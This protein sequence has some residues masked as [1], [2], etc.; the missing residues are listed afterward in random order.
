MANDAQKQVYDN[1]LKR[2]VQ[3]QA[4]AIIPLLLGENDCQVLGEENIEV[5]I[6][7]RRSDRIYT[8]AYHDQRVVI[9]IEY[10]SA[11]SNVMD[12]RL[13]IY[14][15][16]LLEK[17]HCPVIS[18]IVYP[19]EVSMA[20]SPLREVLG[21][22]EI[23]S[24]HYR[25]VPLFKL[26]ART[27]VQ[28]GAVQIYGMLPTMEGVSDELLLQALDEMVQFYEKDETLLREELLCFRI[29]LTRAKRLPDAAMLRVERRIRMFDS[30]LENDPW[31]QEKVAEGRVE[32]KL[33]SRR[34]ILVNFIQTRFPALAETAKAKTAQLSQ[35][36]TLNALMTQL[37]LAP[38]EQAARALLETA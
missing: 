14:H 9:D 2:L 29:L 20:T 36:E 8:L 16:V 22:E 35:L 38:D 34:E 33:S 7:P 18:M 27:F 30:L 24:F 28:Q 11:A 32:E 26:D 4:S 17:Y 15:A 6:P 12:V 23:L 25:T 5:L 19:F 37:W 1:I 3:H 13:L 31:V 10:E 21:D